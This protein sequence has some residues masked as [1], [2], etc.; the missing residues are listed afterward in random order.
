MRFWLAGP[1]YPH[2]NADYT[3]DLTLDGGAGGPFGVWLT[4]HLQGARR[5][6]EP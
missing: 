1:I 6:L 2:T 3:M 5:L 4:E